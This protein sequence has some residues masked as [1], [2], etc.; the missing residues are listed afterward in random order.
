[1]RW[2]IHQTSAGFEEQQE[3]FFSLRPFQRE[4]CP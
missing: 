4:L 3:G 2:Y 1:M